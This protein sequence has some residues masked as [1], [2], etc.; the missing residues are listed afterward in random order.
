MIWSNFAKHGLIFPSYHCSEQ[1]HVSQNK[2]Y[3]LVLDLVFSGC[4]A[5]VTCLQ[6]ILAITRWIWKGAPR[7]PLCLRRGHLPLLLFFFQFTQQPESIGPHSLKN[8][9]V[10]CC[11]LEFCIF[12]CDKTFFFSTS[13]NFFAKWMNA[14]EIHFEKRKCISICKSN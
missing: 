8:S 4:K 13:S 14:I 12:L 5:I 7:R 9:G 2:V 10:S 1:I 3:Y 11:K 6:S